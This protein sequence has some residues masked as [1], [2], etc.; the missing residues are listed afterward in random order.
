M[1]QCCLG[2]TTVKK[3][4]VLVEINK[5]S[6]E[7]YQLLS[8]QSYLQKG[9]VYSGLLRW[10]QIANRRGVCFGERGQGLGLTWVRIYLIFFN[11]SPLFIKKIS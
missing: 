1:V 5:K 4:A 9:L 11:S 3:L 10:G 6:F 2:L 8:I 7:F